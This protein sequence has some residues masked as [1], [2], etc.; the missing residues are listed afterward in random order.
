MKLTGEQAEEVRVAASFFSQFLDHK[1]ANVILT[2]ER[3]EKLATLV[4]LAD[5][6]LRESGFGGL[7]GSRALVS[8]PSGGNFLGRLFQKLKLLW[9]RK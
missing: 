8:S 6:S 4:G 2:P 1:Q 9:V 7:R 3:K 5:E